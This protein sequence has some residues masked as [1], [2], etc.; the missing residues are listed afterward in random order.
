MKVQ[1]PRVGLQTALLCLFLPVV[2]GTGLTVSAVMASR[3]EAMAIRGAEKEIKAKLDAVTERWM[4]I[5]GPSKAFQYF[6]RLDERLQTT[7]IL[8]SRA[9]V[10]TIKELGKI[11][12]DFQIKTLAAV[13]TNGDVY[14]VFTPRNIKSS[15]SQKIPNET[16]IVIQKWTPNSPTT[17]VAAFDKDGVELSRWSEAKPQHWSTT[18]PANWP[19]ILKSKRFIG[20]MVANETGWNVRVG[21]M[22]TLSKTFESG[23][24][25]QVGLN[26]EETQN[27]LASL[28]ESEDTK[29]LLSDLQGRLILSSGASTKDKTG[30]PINQAKDKI[31]RDL[32]PILKSHANK[33][34][35]QQDNTK[36][37]NVNLAGQKWF[38]EI[39]EI[40]SVLDGRKALLTMVLPRDTVLAPA[41]ASVRQAQFI[42]LLLVIAV[43]PVTW[44]VSRS[45]TQQL[46]A[47]AKEASKIR[48]FN[49]ERTNPIPSNIR[50]IEDLGGTVWAM[51]NT[52]QSFLKTSNALASELDF[53]TLLELILKNSISSSGANGVI[54]TI[55][56]AKKEGEPK[57]ISYPDGFVPPSHAKQLKL[58]LDS[59]KQT[60]QGSMALVFDQKPTTNQIAFCQALASSASVALENASLLQSQKNIFDSLIRLVAGAIDAKSPYTGGHCSRVPELT[61]WL[62]EAACDCQEPAF[63]DFSMTENDREVLRLASWL[64][65]C[66]KIITPE[67]VVDKSTKLETIH[68]RIHEIRMRFELIKSQAEAN[69][70]KQ[71][72]GTSHTDKSRQKLDQLKREL[73]NEFAFIAACNMGGEMMSDED[74][75]R[76][77]QIGQR[78]W[79]RTLDDRLG[80][81]SAERERMSHEPAQALPCD[82]PLL[83]DQ[84][85]QK[86]DRT[87]Q[88]NTEANDPHDFNLKTPDLLQNNGEIYNLTIRRGTLNNEERYIIN[89]HIVETIR[90]LESLQLPDHLSTVP[91]IAG[92][93]HERMDGKGYPKGLK[94]D[95]MPPQARMM[96][97]ADVFEALTASDRP[98]KSAKPLSVVMK[99]MVSMVNQHHLDG[100]LFR[101]F[102]EK[103]IHHRYA[104]RYLTQEQRDEVD[105]NMI[106]ASIAL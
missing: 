38:I 50:E 39:S 103:G 82:E 40:D 99:I 101:L 37:Q 66:G 65:D 45:V 18:P 105:D 85:S 93:H 94:C 75:E 76:V 48:N 8:P 72:W 10:K 25:F 57:T 53:E 71:Y 1:L 86:I 88:P 79:V 64:H 55:F 34:G 6:L 84:S 5:R 43:I 42:T 78:T 77:Q 24:T 97:I 19:S 36:L 44:L 52:I 14:Q 13:L 74:V 62:A 80:V 96:A 22:A 98:Y 54:L 17:I 41:M 89:L 7:P 30:T 87:E 29:L 56:S 11:T 63:S 28:I 69:H 21:S 51:S 46:Q 83:S 73:D 100:D 59:R 33:L 35:T 106:L 16:R 67:Y 15:F 4:R 68:N 81:S 92:A 3:M 12:K 2:A 95:E 90:I 23:N 26:L 47:L 27:I 91:A 104:N 58:D 61:Q 20:K 70:W 49:F 32:D 102:V 31:I 60:K 9:E